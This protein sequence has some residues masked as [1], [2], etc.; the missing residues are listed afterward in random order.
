MRILQIT[1]ISNITK[2]NCS[3]ICKEVHLSNR[4]TTNNYQDTLPFDYANI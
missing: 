4:L 3:C 2:Y 1:C